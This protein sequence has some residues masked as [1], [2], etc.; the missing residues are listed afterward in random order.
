MLKFSNTRDLTKAVLKELNYFKKQYTAKP[1]DRLKTENMLWNIAKGGEATSFKYGKY[2]F[3][4]DGKNIYCG[5]SIEKGLCSDLAEYY[6]KAMIMNEDWYFHKFMMKLKIGEIKKVLKDLS[7]TLDK[8]IY[9]EIISSTPG[10]KLSESGAYTKFQFKDEGVVF[11]EQIPSISDKIS[12]S[13]LSKS[14]NLKVNKN[15]KSCTTLGEIAN[16]I[17]TME[18][19]GELNFI[20]L[21]MFIWVPFTKQ[22]EIEDIGLSEEELINIVLKPLNKSNY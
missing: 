8:P 20:L 16:V 5:I 4:Q 7:E 3:M 12:E 22:G 11:L 19:S 21:D 13:E 15:L 6:P 17:S 2:A 18:K 10:V 1:S 14:P 9:I